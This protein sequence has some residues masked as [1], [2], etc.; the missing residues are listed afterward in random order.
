[1]YMNCMPN[2]L[3][4]HATSSYSTPKNLQRTFSFNFCA[5]ISNVKEGRDRP[6]DNNLFFVRIEMPLYTHHID[7]KRWIAKTPYVIICYLY[8]HEMQSLKIIFP[9]EWKTNIHTRSHIMHSSFTQICSD[10][11]NCG[12]YMRHVWCGIILT[13]RKS[14]CFGIIFCCC[15]FF[16][17]YCFLWLRASGVSEWCVAS[18]DCMNCNREHFMKNPIIIYYNTFRIE[19]VR[20][21]I[22]NASH[23]LKCNWKTFHGITLISS[24][25]FYTHCLGGGYIAVRSVCESVH[26]EYTKT[27][28]TFNST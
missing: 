3:N 23:N 19:I 10:M 5:H 28:T 20:T 1:M 22:S 26:F 24:A 27:T 2:V 14:N 7:P 11:F 17:L 25:H 16:S 18:R 6:Y 8:V 4:S 9:E 15:C 13:A 12:V 21:H